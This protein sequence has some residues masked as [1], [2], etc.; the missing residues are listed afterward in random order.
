MNQEE[1]DLE[2]FEGEQG[3]KNLL[4]IALVSG[5]AWLAIGSLII[6]LSSDKPL[7]HSFHS[8]IPMWQELALGLGGGL[9]FGLIAR[10]VIQ[11]KSMQKIIDSLPVIK[12]MRK[13]K[14]SFADLLSISLVA[15]I[16]EEWLFR[17][18]LQP[19]LG[20][21]MSAVL[22]VV[23]HGYIRFTSLAEVFFGAF[24]LALSLGL[25][26]LFAHAGLLAAM[27]AHAMYDVVVMQGL[28]GSKF[29]ENSK[30]EQGRKN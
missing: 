2:P 25:G 15:G 29:E 13:A 30:L 20:L 12:I 21:W 18:A 6:Y 9:I 5:V 22:F 27:F 7:L 3:R 28:E 26:L 16:T 1:P 4:A 23:I 19:L 8:S 10:L 17:A 24:M 14:L 11:Q